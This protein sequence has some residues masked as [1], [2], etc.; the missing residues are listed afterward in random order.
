M[1]AAF[2]VQSIGPS[3]VNAHL[4]R[5]LVRDAYQCI[6]EGRALQVADLRLDIPAVLHAET[7]RVPRSY[8]HIPQRRDH[9]VVLLY[10]P[11]GSDD[12]NAWGILQLIGF[13][14][15]GLDPQRETADD[16]DLYLHL[17]AQG[18]RHIHVAE[19]PFGPAD[20][21]GL[22]RSVLPR[23]AEHLL[24]YQLAAWTE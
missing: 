9:V 1:I 19:P 21:D 22:L 24:D 12:F 11:T 7:R 17:S 18:P 10:T 20:D 2:D 4:Q 13:V 23:L 16:G 15:Q 6:A 3:H 8:M 5:V 14:H